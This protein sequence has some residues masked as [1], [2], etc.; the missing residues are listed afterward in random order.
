MNTNT[1]RITGWLLTVVTAGLLYVLDNPMG[2]LPPL[3][4]LLDP[5]NGCL[6]NAAATVD[7]Y[8]WEQEVPSIKA[9]ATVWI[10]NRLVPHIRASN[11]ADAYYLQGYIHA[12]NRLWQM[13]MQ[14]RAAAGRICEVVGGSALAFDKKQRRKG[15]VYAAENTLKAMEADPRTKGMMD[16]YTAG[17]NDYI[18]GL[19]YRDLPLEYKLMGFRPEPWTNIKIALLL[20]YMADD[21]TGATDDIALTYLRSILPRE[22][23]DRLFPEK[24]AGST[25]VMPTNTPFAAP[26]LS[27]PAMPS[28]QTVFPQFEV[29][30]FGEPKEDGKGSN[31]WAVSGA[32]TASG[33]PILCNDPHLTLN[34][35]SLWYEVQLQTPEMNVYGVSMPGAPGIIIGLNDSLSW[36][37]TNNY[38]DVKDYF[39][40][41]PVEGNPK[42]YWFGGKQLPFTYRMERIGIKGKADLVDTVAYTLHGPVGKQHSNNGKKGLQALLAMCWMAH[43]PS[44]ELLAV[45][46]MN[47]AANYEAF[48]DGMLHFECPGQN[49]LYAD[50]K[51]NIALWGQGQF[52]NKWKGQGRYV[53]D[54]T[55][56]AT[57]W[58]NLI[59]MRENPHALNPTQ[60]YL[61]SANQNVADT[62]YP[63][64]FNGNF[65][66]LRAWRINEVL[67]AMPKATIEDMFALQND[68]KSILAERA[69]PMMLA[70]NQQRTDAYAPLLQGWDYRLTAGSK[71][72]TFFQ[73]WWRYLYLGIWQD[74]FLQVPDF[75]LP[76][77]ERTLQLMQEDTALT[78]YDNVKTEKKETLRDLVAASYDKAVAEMQEAEKATGS[79]WYKVKNTSV[80][81]LAKLAPFSYTG[82]ETGGWGNT[83]NAIKETHG[84]SW[85]MVV[86]MGKDEIEAY[87]VYPGGQSG[88]P[89][90]RHYADF[91]PHWTKGKY[92]RLLFLPNKPQQTDTNIVHTWQITH[93]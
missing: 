73:K 1:S 92:Y 42:K 69:L 63:Y 52:V 79:E 61:A 78:W 82:L 15:M 17:I 74:E 68:T 65:V 76:L 53:M 5:V 30:D 32:R 20:K 43:R 40:I 56:S 84:P 38:R 66:E 13:D 11:D 89:G 36:G 88:N 47:H 9:A 80:N 45:W 28:G 37:F 10:D 48:V 2:S 86:Q 67:R 59:P 49:M 22:S 44:N 75:M 46:G 87:G 35:P 18:S 3:G 8:D 60:G 55:D 81:H 57:L 85:R 26:S 83:V 41:K 23:I 24:I 50:R 4:R 62:S 16:A 6:A 71:A 31:N 12:A 77:P 93:R 58:G 7:Q 29:G 39:L 21:L 51:G 34:L 72:A 33:A 70:M 14:T 19:R 27:A 25:P 90:S 64:W 91:L 54:G